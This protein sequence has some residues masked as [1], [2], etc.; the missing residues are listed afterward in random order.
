MELA[1]FLV[2]RFYPFLK[3]L[4]GILKAKDML[5]REAM[6]LPLSVAGIHLVLE[7]FLSAWSTACEMA[8]FTAIS[9]SAF[10]CGVNFS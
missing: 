10:C 9:V 8:V 6:A 7:S 4:L 3:A 1:S 2:K 5:W